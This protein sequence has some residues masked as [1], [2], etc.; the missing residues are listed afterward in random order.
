MFQCRGGADRRIHHIEHCT[1]ADEVRGGGG[2][3]P[4]CQNATNTKTSHGANRGKQAQPFRSTL[5]GL[6]GNPTL[7]VEV[8][9]FLWESNIFCDSVPKSYLKSNK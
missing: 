3:L 8:Q 6:C 9:H 5:P 2:P 7:S 4:N 1:G